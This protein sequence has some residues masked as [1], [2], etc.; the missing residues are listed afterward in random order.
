MKLIKVTGFL[1][2]E[3]DEYDPSEDGPLTEAVFI[4]QTRALGQLV[5]LEFELAGEEDE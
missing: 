5:D 2:V 3:D 4:Q 1:W